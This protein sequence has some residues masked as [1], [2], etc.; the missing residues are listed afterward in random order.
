MM[1]GGKFADVGRLNVSTLEAFG[2]VLGIHD[3]MT[4]VN[5]NGKVE[6]V[7]TALMEWTVKEC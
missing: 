2:M 1:E 5:K 7:R 4:V 6:M 3:E